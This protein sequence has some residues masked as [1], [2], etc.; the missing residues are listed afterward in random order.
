MPFPLAHPAAVLPLRRFSPRYLNFPALVVGSLTPDLG[1][2]FGNPNIEDFSHQLLA[3]SFGFCLPLGLVLMLGFYLIRLPV[4]CL[5]PARYSQVFIPL[6][7]RPVGSLWIIGPSL[8]LG[9]WTH[10]LLDAF[11]HPQFWLVQ[12][13]PGLIMPVLS[14]GPHRMLLCEF[15]YAGCTFAGVA[16]L[17]TVYLCWWNQAS[18]SPIPRGIRWAYTL[19]LAGLIL[20]VALTCR[21]ASYLIGLGLAG[22]VSVLL[23]LG[24][25]L[26]TGC[27]FRQPQSQK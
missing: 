3:G 20:F 23:V 2:A 13:I 24:F 7:R 15:L 19:L 16:W 17:A 14:F 9:A 4:V 1:Y 5:L 18:G 12:Y 27:H 21:G 25:L 6:C 26:V 22:A 8:L 11:T 10:Q